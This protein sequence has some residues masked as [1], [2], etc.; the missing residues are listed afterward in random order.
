MDD[1]LTADPAAD[2]PETEIPMAETPK[3]EATAA[4]PETPRLNA[5]GVLATVLAQALGM[6]M[7]NV[8]AQQQ[9][10]QT[11]NNAIATKALNLLAEK[12]PI[13]ALEQVRLLSSNQELATTL[14][15]LGSLIQSV[16][17]L[18][19]GDTAQG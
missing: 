9:T 10:M 1:I 12:D 11:I 2:A 13:Q 3:D 14:Q 4:A 17:S 8:V 16:A 15:A 5:G 7:Q 18:N 6:A 19:G